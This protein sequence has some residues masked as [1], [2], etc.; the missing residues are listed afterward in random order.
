MTWTYNL[1]D[2][3]NT[4][5]IYDHTNT[6]VARLDNDGSGFQIKEEILQTMEDAAMAE[7]QANG[8]SNNLMQIL[9]DAIF[10]NIDQ[11]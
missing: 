10:E 6:L 8:F 3:R 7:Y 11:Q 1:A 5:E 4:L 9:R 2:D